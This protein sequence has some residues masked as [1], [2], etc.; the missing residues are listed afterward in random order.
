MVVWSNN[1]LSVYAK[2]E[3]TYVDGVLYYSIEKDEAARVALNAERNR[4]IQKMIAAKKGGAKA[5][6]PSKKEH[7]LYHCD[8]MED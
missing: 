5:D 3:Q 2:A 1:P 7:L 6:K 4:I 8:T